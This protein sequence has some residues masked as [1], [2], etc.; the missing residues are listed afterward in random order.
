MK[1]KEKKELQTKTLQELQVLLLQVKA[2][3]ATLS[4]DMKQGK[5]K[6]TVLVSRRK[7]DIAKIAT[8]LRQKESET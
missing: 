2:E 6:D 4:F 8:V 1:T 7:K 3:V 5:V